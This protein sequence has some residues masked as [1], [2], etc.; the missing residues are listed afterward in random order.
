MNI[1]QSVWRLG[2]FICG[3]V[4]IGSI[5]GAQLVDAAT[6]YTAT[7]GND[8]NPGTEAKPFRTLNRGVKLLKPGDTLRVKSGTYAE[9]LNNSIPGGTSWSAPVTVAAY[10]GHMVTLR[11]TTSTNIITISGS[12][13]RFIIIDGLIIDGT[14]STSGGISIGVSGGTGAQNIRL[15]NLEIKNTQRSG[16]MGD[17]LASNLTLT[18]MRIHRTGLSGRG[19]GFYIATPNATVE[20]STIYDNEKCGGQFYD[21]NDP[22]NNPIFRHN[23]LY[24]NALRGTQEPNPCDHGVFV[25]T[26]NGAQVYNNVFH[27]SPNGSGVTLSGGSSNVKVYNNT[28][29]KNKRGIVVNGNNPLIKNNIAYLNSSGNITT[30]GGRPT[31]SNNLTSNPLFVDP[32]KNNF[33]LQAASPAID[34]GAILSEV[35]NDFVGVPRPQGSTYD[36]GAYEHSGSR[37]GSAPAHLRIVGAN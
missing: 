37:T 24:N 32:A 8:A 17:V 36:I 19:H 11:P 27:N 23:V 16:V 29:Y 20:Y 26:G 25:G 35:K 28:F 3:V 6:Y 30:L 21:S 18:N 4:L 7:T 31:L 10:P 15:Q 12:S 2:S 22:V 33:K 1:K 13:K 14:N 34:A 9:S 5:L